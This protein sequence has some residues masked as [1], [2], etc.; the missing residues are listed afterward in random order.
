MFVPFLLADRYLGILVSDLIFHSIEKS[1][2]NSNISQKREE[3][4]YQFLLQDPSDI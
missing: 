3:T 4:R 2:E 1:L